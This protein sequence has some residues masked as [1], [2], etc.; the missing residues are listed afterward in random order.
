MGDFCMPLH[1]PIVKDCLDDNACYAKLTVDYLNSI[2]NEID[3]WNSVSFWSVVVVGICSI[4]A[5]IVIAVQ[6]TNN[7]SW[8]RPI[9]IIATSLVT[10]IT[11]L[12][13]TFHIPDTKQELAG[14]SMEMTQS[15]NDF[16]H[17]VRGKSA[18]ESEQSRKSYADNFA[19]LKGRLVMIDKGVDVSKLSS[20]KA[21]SKDEK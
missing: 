14:I 13:G 19:K 12:V 5:T 10:G 17:D 3:Y 18:D 9:G 20:A 15:V 21:N 1:L 6:D 11:A 7:K 8:T 2:G 4:I 16:E